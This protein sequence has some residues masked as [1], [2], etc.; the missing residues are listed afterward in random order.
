MCALLTAISEVLINPS[1]LLNGPPRQQNIRPS[2]RIALFPGFALTPS[3]RPISD[4]TFLTATAIPN[5]FHESSRAEIKRERDL[6]SLTVVNH[7]KFQFLYTQRRTTFFISQE[8]IRFCPNED[9]GG[10]VSHS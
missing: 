8:I 1:N 9:V 2:T 4:R 6:A 7:R 10:P 5:A 3:R